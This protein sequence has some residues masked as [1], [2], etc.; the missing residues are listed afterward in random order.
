MT[1]DYRNML[2][3]KKQ[4]RWNWDSSG[5]LRH[6][7]DTVVLSLVQNVSDISGMEF[8]MYFWR[9]HNTAMKLLYQ[10]HISWQQMKLSDSSLWQISL[11]PIFKSTDGPDSYSI[12]APNWNTKKSGP[13]KQCYQLQNLIW[14]HK[15]QW[16]F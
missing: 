13:T 6:L 9:I 14:N 7:Q 16:Y 3:V 15:I 4:Q 5:M 2:V 12:L 11:P 1:L 10:N 8:Y